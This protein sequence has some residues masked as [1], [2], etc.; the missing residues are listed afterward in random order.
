MSF[1]EK[2]RAFLIELEALTRK[3]QLAV[4]GCGC[5]DS[6]RLDE[7]DDSQFDER[8]GYGTDGVCEIAWIAPEGNWDWDHYSESIVKNDV[9]AEAGSDEFE[10][11]MGTTPGMW[12]FLSDL[13]AEEE[14]RLPESLNKAIYALRAGEAKVVPR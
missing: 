6:P 4:A 9:I 11:G 10:S 8:A 13:L 3:Y 7:L 14:E 5:C 2:Q 1:T 12:G